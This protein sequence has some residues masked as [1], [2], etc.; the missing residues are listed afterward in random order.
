MPL[1]A[2]FKGHGRQVA[3]Q[4]KKRYGADWQRHFYAIANAKG[5]T[6]KKKR[7]RRD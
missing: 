1:D 7:K 2:Y 4:M 6:P 5:M 3:E